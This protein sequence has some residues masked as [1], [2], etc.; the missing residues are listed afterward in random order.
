MYANVNAHTQTLF[1]PFI[2]DNNSVVTY[3]HKDH[4]RTEWA[5]VNPSLFLPY[6][7]LEYIEKNK[8][9]II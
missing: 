1:I 9:I 4:I 8:A 2:K 3:I 5:T 6:L 7:Y